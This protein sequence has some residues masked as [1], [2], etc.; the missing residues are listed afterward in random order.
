[1]YIKKL[2]ISIWSYKYL[3]QL[4]LG[5]RDTC[6]AWRLINMTL[7]RK[8]GKRIGGRIT[9]QKSQMKVR[10][11]E[12]LTGLLGP[13]KVPVM[14]K[15]W[16]RRRRSAR[17]IRNR[18]FTLRPHLALLI[19]GSRQVLGQNGKQ[20]TGHVHA[21]R[22]CLSTMR[23]MR[24]WRTSHRWPSSKTTRTGRS[25]ATWL[26]SGS[27]RRS[28]PPQCLRWWRATWPRRHWKRPCFQSWQVGN[29]VV[30][31]DFDEF[32]Y[33]R[34]QEGIHRGLHKRWRSQK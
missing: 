16:R 9:C 24:S 23:A 17:S 14:V 31:L 20:G 2:L 28:T 8:D 18:V 11:W 21:D 29:T 26:S 10:P 32:C 33:Y 5:I 1:M 19:L 15:A 22:E 25:A 12:S 34:H 6:R 13:N 30:R 27:T 3:N 4:N 7:T